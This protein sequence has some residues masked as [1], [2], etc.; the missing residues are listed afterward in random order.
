MGAATTKHL[1][2]VASQVA[3][4][5]GL[6]V[7]DAGRER[8]FLD[9]LPV[10]LIWGV[11]PVTQARLAGTGIRT[12]GELAATGASTLEHLL[13]SAAGVKLTALSANRD[14]R[15]VDAG[16]AAGSVGA[17]AAVGSR[18]AGPEFVRTTLGYLADR[19]AGRLRAAGLAGRTV[20]V[21]VRFPGL[22]SVTRSSTLPVAVSAT[23]TVTEVATDLAEAALADDGN[24]H[25]SLL[26]VS[27]SNLVAE[28]VQQLEL[29]I[30]L[31][32]DPQRPGTTS[33]AAR[34]Q[35]DRSV[36]AIRARFGRRS[37]GYATV[38]LSPEPG[39]RKLS[40]SW[41]N[42]GDVPGQLA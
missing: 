39:S 4:P 3:K 32:A 38:A 24:R 15:R 20:T 26:G 19:V 18:E 28:P 2:K 36:D 27:V 33:G 25:L 29:P 5:D 37:V 9:P 31:A 42:A 8:A 21:R 34:W 40:E 10:E 23:L 13:G 14:P 35:V 12:I 16:R 22:R 6:V 30:G 11:G 17:Q 7:V 1:A 41:L